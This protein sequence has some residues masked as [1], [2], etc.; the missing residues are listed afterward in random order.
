MVSCVEWTVVQYDH[1][2]KAVHSLLPA[3]QTLSTVL[4][5][6]SRTAELKVAVS[7]ATGVCGGECCEW[8][9]DI[10][11]K[12]AEGGGS[13]AQHIAGRVPEW[14]WADKLLSC[15]VITR[16]TEWFAGL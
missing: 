8:S 4:V 14:L 11:A 13:M 10:W 6:A 7:G 16:R 3:H 12:R 2:V 15:W 1:N 5:P 9:G